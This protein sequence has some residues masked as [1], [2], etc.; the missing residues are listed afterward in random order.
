MP[1]PRE[2]TPRRRWIMTAVM[3]LIFLGTLGMAA[4]IA[5]RP[6]LGSFGGNVSL[7]PMR[8]IGDV[9]VA[10]PAGWEISDDR[11]MLV[12]S[13]LVA[14]EPTDP[15]D[16]TPGRHLLVTVE[17]AG[18]RFIDELLKADL[19]RQNVAIE[20][21]RQFEIGQ[22]PGG[23]MARGMK[24][25]T[26]GRITGVWLSAAAR[27]PGTDRIVRLELLAPR[28]SRADV[29]LLRRV[30]ASVEVRPPTPAER[31]DPGATTLPA[32][33]PSETPGPSTD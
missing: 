15:R 28:S 10:L 14:E 32:A 22:L 9:S 2:Y 6:A 13:R 31:F 23:V 24:L 17:G 29:L 30:A 1:F 4:A 8:E 7:G 26:G 3:W 33:R 20:S 12:R 19:L 25:G 27:L 18:D 11:I 5:Y 16:E 21:M